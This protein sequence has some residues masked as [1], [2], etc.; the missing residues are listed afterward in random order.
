MSVQI[1]LAIPAAEG[2]L[3]ELQSSPVVF[4]HIDLHP[5]DDFTFHDSWDW[6]QVSSERPVQVHRHQ[7][8]F[9]LASLWVGYQWSMFK[10]TLGRLKLTMDLFGC[11][12]CPKA[13]YSTATVAAWLGSSKNNPSVQKCD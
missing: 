12:D 6:Q 5:Y 1:C 13:G 2:D 8:Q 10:D 4:C 9:K 7:M 3:P 11:L